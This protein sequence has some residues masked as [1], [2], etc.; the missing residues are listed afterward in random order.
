MSARAAERSLRRRRAAPR[1]RRDPPRGPTSG[2][3]KRTFSSAACA[4]RGDPVVD[5]SGE[6]PWR[7]R[8]LGAPRRR[9]HG[10]HGADAS[11]AAPHSPQ[12]FCV[13]AVHRAARR[14]LDLRRLRRAHV[15][16]PF[17]LR[18]RVG[19]RRARTRRRPRSDAS[20]SLA[21]AMQEHVDEGARGSGARGRSCAGRAAASR[22]ASGRPASGS[23]PRTGVG[24]SA[25]GRRSRR[26]RRGRSARRSGRPLPCSGLMYSGVPQT[27]PGLVIDGFSS[28][29]RT[30]ASPKSTTFTK[31]PPVRIGSR[32]MFS[33]FRSRWMMPRWC[34]SLSAASVCRRTFT[35]RRND[36][37]PSS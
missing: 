22:C 8:M 29:S 35:M 9:R 19:E 20:C 26:R 16:G 5:S 27:M 15:R 14:A 31:S 13:G 25:S 21:I 18:H 3:G 11:I 37:G 1:A 2:S 32:M 30:L 33:G 28:V 6:R 17:D 10:R 7:G 34:A 36:S 23:R 24:R 12:N 4:P